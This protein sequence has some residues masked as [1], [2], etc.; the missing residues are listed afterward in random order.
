MLAHDRDVAPE[1]LVDLYASVGWAAYTYEPQQLHEAVRA[2]TYVVTAWADGELVG[3]ARG[4]SDDVSIFYLQDI[5]VRPSHQ[6]RGVG[7]RLLRDCIE[8]FDHVR[9]KVLLT[10]GDP[11]QDAL[12][13]GLGYVPTEEFEEAPLTAYVRIDR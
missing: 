6:Q 7:T 13:R 1:Q 4:L 10:D 2:S 5:L 11:A 3:L 8:R 9:Q 12:Y